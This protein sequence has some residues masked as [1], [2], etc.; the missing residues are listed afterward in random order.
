[1]ARP[2]ASG[3]VRVDTYAMIRDGY[4]GDGSDWSLTF[5]YIERIRDLLTVRGV[6]LW[7][8]LYP[9]GHQIS[10]R[11]WND[12]RVDWS[13]EH[14]RVYTRAPQKQVEELGRSR[15]ISVINMTGDFRE[16]SK[17]EFPPCRRGRGD[18][19]RAAALSAAGRSA[20]QERRSAQELAGRTAR[21]E[22]R[23]MTRQALDSLRGCSLRRR[24]Q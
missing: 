16:R 5:G 23:P 3:D 8:T 4:H 7:L 12:G 13:F 1:M 15:D 19:P 18:F 21:I 9:Y 2:D 20:H 10:P 11:E 6:P 24:T 22:T 17:K 14:N